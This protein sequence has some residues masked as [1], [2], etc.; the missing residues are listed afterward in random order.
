M[1]NQEN[2]AGCKTSAANEG[3][4]MPSCVAASLSTSRQAEKRRQDF[5]ADLMCRNTRVELDS[6]SELYNFHP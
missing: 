3:G 6:M 2:L 1:T 5:D 4:R